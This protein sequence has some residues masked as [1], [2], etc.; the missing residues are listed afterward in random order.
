MTSI[1]TKFSITDKRLLASRMRELKKFGKISSFAV[2]AAG[3]SEFIISLTLP[4]ILK[5]VA[6]EWG[7]DLEVTAD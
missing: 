2:K 1:N 6:S 4:V 7:V 3:G 5:T